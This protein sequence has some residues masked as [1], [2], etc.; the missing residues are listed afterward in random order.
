LLHPE[1]LT[2]VF[3]EPA[4]TLALRTAGEE[5]ASFRLHVSTKNQLILMASA[6]GTGFTVKFTT[7]G[8][9]L[10]DHLF[11]H[12]SLLQE[13]MPLRRVLHVILRQDRIFEN[14]VEVGLAELKVGANFARKSSMRAHEI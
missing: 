10:P 2:E 8:P 11:V 13:M 7:N 1:Y 6:E 14:T 4:R 5:S 9:D 12:R 3:I